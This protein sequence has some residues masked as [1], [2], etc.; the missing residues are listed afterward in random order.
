MN[1]EQTKTP[2][3]EAEENKGGLIARMEQIQ[4]RYG[5]LP[6][7]ELNAIAAEMGRSMC[8]QTG[9]MLRS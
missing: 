2:V 6:K 3:E 9:M 7:D 5:Y 4:A 1:P 8:F